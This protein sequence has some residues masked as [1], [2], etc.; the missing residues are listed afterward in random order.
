[1]G[2][3]NGI[4]TPGNDLLRLP[5]IR[6]FWS[7]DKRFL[8][9]FSENKITK[10]VPLTK[11]PS[12]YDDISFWI[13][14][15]EIKIAEDKDAEDKDAK[16]KNFTWEKLND[17][18]ELVR[19]VYGEN[20]EKVEIYDKFYHPKKNKYSYTMRLYVSPPLELANGAEF[21]KITNELLKKICE[22][23]KKLNVGL[24]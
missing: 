8:S 12:M 6:L 22:Q 3:R 13:D 14:N 16:D 11:L 15:K 7:T 21:K 9:Q 1:M 4:R 5:D 18:Y 23:M 24:R 20:V 19:E 10:F 17:F 2:I